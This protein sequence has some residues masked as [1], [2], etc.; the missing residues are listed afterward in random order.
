MQVRSLR[1]L[2]K[3]TQTCFSRFGMKSTGHCKTESSDFY[4]DVFFLFD[5]TCVEKDSS[6]N[7]GASEKRHGQCSERMVSMEDRGVTLDTLCSPA[8]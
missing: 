5:E 8:S 6:F 1:V 2:S 3:T 4:L 7:F